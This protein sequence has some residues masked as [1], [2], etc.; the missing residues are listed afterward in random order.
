MVWVASILLFAVLI[1]GLAALRSYR[2]SIQDEESA[3]GMQ[4]PAD[5]LIARARAHDA[6]RKAQPPPEN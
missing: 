6:A 2:R 5:V 4:V 1:A 3:P